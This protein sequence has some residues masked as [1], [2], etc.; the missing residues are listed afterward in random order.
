MIII[1][2]INYLFLVLLFFIFI[3]LFQID[4]IKLIII[5][6]TNFWFQNLI[7]AIFPF[8]VISDL[9]I[10]YGMTTILNRLTIIKKLFKLSSSGLFIIILSMITGLPSGAIYISKLLKEDL[11][12]VEEANRIIYFCHFSNPLFIINTIG[13][14]ILGN[15]TLGYFI[16]L[17]HYLSNFIITFIFKNN[18]NYDSKIFIHN[19]EK[20][21]KVFSTSII[22]TF[23]SLLIILGNIISFQLLL[24]IIFN[25]IDISNEIDAFISLFLEISNG[26]TQLKLLNIN[27][28][29]KSAIITSA[30]SFG[31]LCIHSQV[32][33]ILSDT[34]IKYKNYLFG[35]IVQAIL[36][37][38]IFLII[39]F[40]HCV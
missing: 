34:K 17:S 4:D 22:N 40:F 3:N 21:G 16:L 30:I 31:G 29:L 10:N 28:I 36:A 1:K 18:C 35:R 8:Y 25:Y 26:L 11:I 33:T 32:Y 13:L 15:K 7:P 39:C 24:T 20:L 12:S 37:P 6:S 19:Q 9:L 14:N 38:L 5:N 27:I 23:N 2:K